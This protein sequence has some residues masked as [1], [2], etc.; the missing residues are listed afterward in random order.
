MR[1]PLRIS[2]GDF[3]ALSMR[4]L[5]LIEPVSDLRRKT[6]MRRRFIGV[7][8][9]HLAV[10]IGSNGVACCSVERAQ[11]QYPSIMFK[12]EGGVDFRLIIPS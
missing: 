10:M 3:L 6:S 7:G 11:R 5:L 4:R 8:R 1:A 9:D 12:Q 2:R